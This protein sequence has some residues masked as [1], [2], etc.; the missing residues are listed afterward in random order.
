MRTMSVQGLRGVLAQQTSEWFAVLLEI[1][2]A[3]LGTPIRLVNNYSSLTVS[4]NVYTA[5]PFEFTLPD[6][7]DD[8]EPQAVLT[9]DNT[10][11]MLMSTIRSISSPPSVSARIVRGANPTDIEWGPIAFLVRSVQYDSNYVR[12][13]LSFLNYS[14]EPFPYINFTPRLF[15]GLFS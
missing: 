14:E 11:R 13:K 9:I 1:S 6:E 12:F 8:R 5:Y 7:Q 4:G 10:D 2:H 3:S 15:P